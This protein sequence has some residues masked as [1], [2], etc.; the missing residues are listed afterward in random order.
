MTHFVGYL[1][2]R[3]YAVYRRH[4]LERA[5]TPRPVQRDLRDRLVFRVAVLLAVLLVAFVATKSCAVSRTQS[6]RSEAVA[7]AQK[8]D[9]LRADDAPGALPPAGHA[10]A[11]YYWA[12]NFCDSEN[13]SGQIVRTRSSRERDH[14]RCVAAVGEGCSKPP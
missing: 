8:D 13:E 6:A 3:A 9:R 10:A 12:V 14:R 1:F 11:V 2:L 4:K 5:L 7:I